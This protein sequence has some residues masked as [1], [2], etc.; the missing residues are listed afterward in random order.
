MG[1]GELFGDQCKW[2][3][4]LICSSC[5]SGLLLQA[6]MYHRPVSSPPHP[7]LP[8]SH[9]SSKQGTRIWP[10]TMRDP[11]G[12]SMRSAGD[13]FAQGRFGGCCEGRELMRVPGCSDFS[14]PHASSEQDVAL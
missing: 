10:S 6:A 1:K 5:P 7:A 14:H 12:R 13:C 9:T 11:G 2:Y 4:K 8:L 3:S